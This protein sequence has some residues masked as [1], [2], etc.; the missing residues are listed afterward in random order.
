ME[1]VAEVE[2][3]IE[4]EVEK[5]VEELSGTDLDRKLSDCLKTGMLLIEPFLPLLPS[6]RPS[7]RPSPRPSNR[8]GD[9]EGT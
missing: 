8:S 7:P 9:D 3:E 1:V 6:N 2:D 4:D 5:A